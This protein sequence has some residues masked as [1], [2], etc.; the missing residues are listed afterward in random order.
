MENQAIPSARTIAKYPS[1]HTARHCR[2]VRKE[3][4]VIEALV[5]GHMGQKITDPHPNIEYHAITNCGTQY[6]IVLHCPSLS[7]YRHLRF[8]LPSL[9]RKLIILGQESPRNR[10]YVEISFLRRK[11]ISHPPPPPRHKPL[12]KY[13]DQIYGC[14]VLFL[15]IRS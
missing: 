7:L 11:L 2:S 6:F 10:V 15:I 9:Y 3:F 14:Q 1:P 13:P 12:D 8:N 4:S 5:P